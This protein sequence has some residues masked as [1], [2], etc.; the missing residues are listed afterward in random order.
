MGFDILGG[1]RAVRADVDVR[2][3]P[4]AFPGRT[5]DLGDNWVDPIV[6]GRVQVALNDRWSATA[7]ADVGGSGGGSDRTWQ[8]V[9]TVGYQINDRWS[10]RGGWRHISVEKEMSGRDVEFDMSGPVL[11]LT[12]RF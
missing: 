2:L 7:M 5:F 4:G 1:F 3:S 10:V 8:A 12:A 11:G 6:G 9:A